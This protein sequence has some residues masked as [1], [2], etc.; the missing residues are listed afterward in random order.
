MTRTARIWTYG[1]APLAVLALG[2]GVLV[3]PGNND[4]LLS[5]GVASA[6]VAPSA[7]PGADATEPSDGV[8][9]DAPQ[10]DGESTDP[11]RGSVQANTDRNLSFDLRLINATIDRVNLDSDEQ[12]FVRFQFGTQIDEVVDETAFLLVGLDPKD[13]VK[14]EVAFRDEDDLDTVLV[15]FPARTDV[16]S[17]TLAT[18]APGAVQTVSNESNIPDS[19]P[20]TGSNVG[21]GN[22]LTT[23]PDLLSVD[24]DANLERAVFVFDE[25]LDE[26]QKPSATSFGYYTDSGL[27][28]RGS[29]VVSVEDNTV[30]VRFDEEG[31][32][33]IEDAARLWVDAGAVSDTAGN[34][35]PVGAFGEQTSAPDLQAIED[36]PGQTQFEFV[37]DDEVT[38]AKAASFAVY[39]A[40]GTRYTAESVT[41][42]DSQ[43]VRA[44]FPKIQNFGDEVV[45]ASVDRE[46]VKADGGFDTPNTVGALPIWIAGLAQ[47]GTTGPDLIG[48]Q[49]D[50]KTGQATLTF[51]EDID[52]DKT[53]KASDL[54]LITTSG[55]MVAAESIVESH[56]R[57]MIVTFRPNVAKAA[58]GLTINAGA[59]QDFQ[60]NGNPLDTLAL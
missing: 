27:D 45:L 19:V 41:R 42:P 22:G 33:Q 17:H 31:G 56:H 4:P 60:E 14:S 13:V 49:L 29:D 43:R 52:D 58:D 2:V 23:G 25:Q 48:V 20:L 35:N 32:D 9:D 18:A 47:G 12:E 37:F 7:S 11:L 24:I 3:G 59:V 39:T 30:T 21:T 16:H 57:T 10:V 44:A 1:I 5:S 6:Q 8:I 50:A 26:S 40:D 55:Q 15:G 46:A 53:Y 51:D 54:Y 36:G 38:E 28:P 34:T